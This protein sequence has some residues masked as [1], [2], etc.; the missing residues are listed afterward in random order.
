MPALCS[1]LSGTYYAQ[2]YAGI[3]GG[4]LVPML[5]CKLTM[6]CFYR[7]DKYSTASSTYIVN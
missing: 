1:M 2:N 7:H 5:E 6:Q 3:I 4:S